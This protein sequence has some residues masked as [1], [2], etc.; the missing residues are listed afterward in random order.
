MRWEGPG[1]PLYYGAGS[2]RVVRL[3]IQLMHPP[4]DISPSNPMVWYADGAKPGPWTWLQPGSSVRRER[5]A[6]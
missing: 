5:V 2:V 4:S 6:A 3:M 1:D